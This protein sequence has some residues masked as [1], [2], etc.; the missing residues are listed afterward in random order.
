[1]AR[2][3]AVI[4]ELVLLQTRIPQADDIALNSLARATGEAKASHLR[5]SLG[6]Y[7]TKF[8]LANHTTTSVVAHP[9]EKDE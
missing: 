8:D 3:E 4:G 5:R 2:P 9:K 6:Q 7:L 1:M